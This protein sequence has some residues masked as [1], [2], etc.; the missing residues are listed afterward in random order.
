MIL[1]SYTL[2]DTGEGAKLERFGDRLIVRPSS[3]AVW[4]RRDKSAWN[5]VWASYGENGKW[6]VRGSSSD[7]TISGDG[8]NLILRLQD[9]GQI[10]VFPEHS[11][12]LDDVRSTIK[13]KNEPTL[14]NLFAYTGMCSVVAAKAGALVTHVDTSK[15]ALDWALQNFSH[16]QISNIRVIKED[17]ISFMKKE[18]RRGKKYDVLVVDPPGFSRSRD[19]SWKIEEVISELCDLITSLINPDNGQAFFTFHGNEFHP[20]S[21]R[22]LFLDTGKVAAEAVSVRLLSLSDQANRRLSAGA[23]ISIGL[24]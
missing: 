17:A 10:G 15:S 12:Y 21:V 16:N 18:V 22:N 7:W 4:K 19:V 1:N 23:L 6:S 24:R 13:G 11:T 9:N 5:N 2:I 3:H 8:F 20:E 14:L